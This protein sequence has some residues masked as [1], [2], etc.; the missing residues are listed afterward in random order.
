MSSIQKA[1]RAI[2]LV[3]A[4]LAMQQASAF[5]LGTLQNEVGAVLQSSQGSTR[6]GTAVDALS[7][8][9]VNKGLK[10]AL[11]RGV[12]TAVA[13]LGRPD[14]FYGNKQWRIPL[15]SG[16]D[17]AANLMRMAG[18]GD[19]VDA[20]ELAINRAAEAAVPQAKALLASAVKDMSIADAKGILTGGDQAAT[21]YFRRKTSSDLVQQF[22]P[23][24]T[25]ATAKV[26]LARTYNSYAGQGAQFGLIRNEDA[27]LD[28][29]VAKEAVNRLYQAIGEQEKA[30]RADPV[31]SGSAII[32]KVFGAVR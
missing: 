19:Q 30:L 15:P 17:K 31:G 22:T 3:S 28:H 13:T 20:L 25:Q 27:N 24:V 32:G 12:D 21:E 29:Y 1:G 16:L 9:E 6:S 7:P 5:D 8:G 26:G 2:L 23:I 11:S 14:G 4:A 18:R 10:A